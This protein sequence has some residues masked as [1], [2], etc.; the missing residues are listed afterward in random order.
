MGSA[1]AAYLLDGLAGTSLM[2][3]LSLGSVSWRAAVAAWV[4]IESLAVLSGVGV[5]WV[6]LTTVVELAGCVVCAFAALCAVRCSSVIATEVGIRHSGFSFIDSVF[7]VGRWSHAGA[8]RWCDRKY[9]P[10]L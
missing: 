3:P 7:Q 6:A 8:L 9:R 5:A 1:R 2:E 10:S 4:V